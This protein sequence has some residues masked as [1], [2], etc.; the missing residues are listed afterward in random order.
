MTT[1]RVLFHV[2]HLLGIGHWRRALAIARAMRQEGLAVTMLSGGPPEEA[3]ELDGIAVEQLAPVRAADASFATLVDGEGRPLD[4]AL[5]ARRRAHLLDAFARLRPAIVLIESFPFGRRAFAFELAPLIAAARAASPRPAILASIR[6]VL[7][8]KEN[9]ARAAAIVETVRRDFARVLV[10]GDPD[11]VQLEASFPPA[12]EIADRLVYTGY[13]VAAAG[14]PDDGRT[15][16][17]EVVV[18]A[19]GGAVGAALLRAALAARALSSVAAAPWRLLAGPHLPAADFA[20]L[21]AR[22]PPGVALERFRPD[23]PAMLFRCR[24]S[25]SQGGYNTVLDLL[26]AGTRAI[27]VPFAA[28]GETEQA[29][30]AAL[31]AARGAF[32]LLPDPEL[33]GSTLAAAIDQVLAAPPPPRLAIR[34]DGAAETARTVAEL[35]RNRGW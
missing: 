34:R 25:I 11:L 7:V 2:Q 5:R 33:D 21:A 9:P 6:D 8:A 3:G 28:A 10:H 18:S 35:A 15:G 19:G 26:A 27:V 29:Q 24:L 17:G 16:A 20:A 14:G 12:A 23:F 4:D 13:V 1:P 22:L 32:R 30:R 31:L